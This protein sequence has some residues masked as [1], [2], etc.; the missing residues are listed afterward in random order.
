MSSADRIHHVSEAEARRVAEAA[1]E[2]EWG[3]VNFVRDLFL[4]RFDIRALYPY[5][6]PESFISEESRKWIERFRVFLRDEVDSDRIDREGKIPPAVVE[7]LKELGAFGM[8]VPKEYG[9]LGF[10]Q[11]E[12]GR[13]MEVLGSADGNLVALISAHQSIG[14]PQPLKLFGT[15]EQKKKYLPRIAKGT[16]TAFA[17][18]EDDVGSDPARLST[19]ATPTEDGKAFILNGEKLWITNGTIADLFVVMARNPETNRISAFIVEKEWEGVEVVERCHFMGLRALENGVIRFTDVRV[20]RENLLWKEGRG[21]KLAL[22]TLNTGRLT[23]PA[24]AVGTARACLEWCREWASERVQWGAKIGKHEA[25]AHYIA[26]IASNTFALKAVAELSSIMADQPEKFDIRLEAAMAKLW[27][28]EVGWRLVDDAIQVR[29]GRGYETADSLKA[30]GDEPVPVERMLRDFRI[31]RIFEGS[32]EI[33]RLFIAREAVDHHLDMAG[34]LVEGDL[35]PWEKLKKLPHVGAYYALW[36]PSR[37]IGWSRWPRYGQFGNLAGH[38]RFVERTSRKLA[39]TL[40][41]LMV[42]HGAKLQ[43]RQGL[44]F[45]AVDVGAELFAMT[46]TV[47]R[48]EMLQRTGAPGADEAI[49]LADAF[50]RGSRRR[51][52]RLFRQMR[53]NLDVTRYRLAQD[54]LE[55]NFRWLE[56]PIVGR[57]RAASVSTAPSPPAVEAKRQPAVTLPQRG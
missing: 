35:T 1:R 24:A 45:R 19:S 51:I 17:L 54:V 50:C 12:F 27:N 7:R 49:R 53:S 14:V 32:S 26:D 42:R 2:K 8:K 25:V 4:G 43:R 56:E 15:P 11:T 36:Y 38:L 44:L 46:A 13:V 57:Q 22:V 47:L 34:E 40:F 16:I 28:T 41:H 9:G 30:R 52:K 29:G 5:P 31:N 39:R 48:A 33:M 6:D 55:G 37:W 21:L 20:P 18:T 10:S 23:I 3:G